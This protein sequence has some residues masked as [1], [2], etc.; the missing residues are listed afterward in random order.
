MVNANTIKY[1]QN[2]LFEIT[3][4]KRLKNGNCVIESKSEH[5]NT[6]ET[7]WVSILRHFDIYKTNNPSVNFFSVLTTFFF[8]LQNIQPPK[9]TASGGGRDDVCAVNQFAV[10]SE[11][12][13]NL[14]LRTLAKTKNK[15]LYL[16]INTSW[17]SHY[18]LSCFSFRISFS[19]HIKQT[20][21]NSTNQP[22]KLGF[23]IHVSYTHYMFVCLLFFPLTRISRFLYP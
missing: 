2:N 13:T 20:F 14:W 7:K 19:R 5:L 23:C 15:K 6:L 16:F 4:K 3:R 9:R 22:T 18:D 10:R 12:G 11:N 8:F 21:Q 1:D 17:T